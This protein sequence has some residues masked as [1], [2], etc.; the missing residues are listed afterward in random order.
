MTLALVLLMLGTMQQPSDSVA[1]IVAATNSAAAVTD[2]DAIRMGQL[3]ALC[4]VHFELPV[5]QVPIV[6]PPSKA[7]QALGAFLR[8]AADAGKEQQ[9]RNNDIRCTSQQIGYTIETECH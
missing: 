9:Q 1:R 7:R 2:P 4:E 3:R 5:L 8:G 6:K